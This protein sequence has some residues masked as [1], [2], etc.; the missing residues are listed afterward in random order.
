[1][2][3][4]HHANDETG[5]CFP[6][7]Q[8]ISE[9][10]GIKERSLIYRLKALESLGEISI[11]R[12]NGAGHLTRYKLNLTGQRVQAVAPFIE[13]KGC[14]IVSKRVQYPVQKGAISG[15]AYKEEQKEQKE[16][17]ESPFQ[18]PGIGDALEDTF[19]GHASNF[20]LMGELH[21][22]CEKLQATADD[23]R[24]FPDWL[25]KTY[26]MKAISP[27]ALKD[28][29]SES[30]KSRPVVKIP[31]PNLCPTCRG[32]KVVL[33]NGMDKFRGGTP[34]MPCPDCS[35]VTTNSSTEKS[36]VITS[37]RFAIA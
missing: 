30:L 1:M 11:S 15:S 16:Q 6:S 19:P 36:N 13:E 32:K 14:N 2:I 4:A 27:F 37:N 25:K 26:P 31:D 5:E 33:K 10:S 21:Q 20:R 34:T 23:V 7:R 17:K 22:L 12:G 8:L 3:L 18:N 29:L 24:R 9:E 35:N 28:L